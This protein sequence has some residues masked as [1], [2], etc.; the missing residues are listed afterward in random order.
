MANPVM[1]FEIIGKDA[2]KLQS[3]YKD[4][5]GW[6]MTEPAGPQFGDYSQLENPA[7]EGI[8][9]GIG[10]AMQGSGAR[11][12]VYIEV[13]DPDAYLKKVE[14]KGGKT[15]MPT[16]T[17]MPG[18]TIALFADPEGNVTGLMKAGG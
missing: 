8:N 9:G 6:K 14:S 15:L 3:F 11:V 7:G 12:S 16:T 1:W 4:V 10:G 13:N 5:F 17:I 18:T 2:R